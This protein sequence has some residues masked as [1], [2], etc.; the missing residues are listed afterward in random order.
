MDR[1]T[2]ARHVAANPASVALLLSDDDLEPADVIVSSPRRAG[3]GFSADVRIG[4]PH[5]A[6]GTLTITPAADPGCDLT[7]VLTPV[8]S[9]D[10]RY[11]SRAARSFVDALAGRARS[12]SFAA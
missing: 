2:I 4:E 11:A 7:V 1:V 3:V 10:D 6:T 5:A 12:R 8:A 9:G